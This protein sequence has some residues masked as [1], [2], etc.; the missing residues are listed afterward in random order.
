MFLTSKLPTYQQALEVAKSSNGV[1]YETKS[2]I[3]GYDI[4]VF[5]YRLSTYSDFVNYRGFELRG[6]TFVFN[7]DG[8][9]FATYPLLTKFFNLNENP[10]T[11]IKVLEDKRISKVFLKEDGS[12]I[13][14]IKLP[15]GKILPKSKVGLSSFQ[16]ELSKQLFEVDENLKHFVTSCLDLGLHPIFELVSNKN[17]IVINYNTTKLILLS[18]RNNSGEYLDINDFDWEKPMSFNFSLSDLISLKSH[19]T[20]IEG[21]VV[22]FDD[23]QRVKIKTDWYLSLHRVLT[24]YS[25]REDYLIDMILSEKIDDLLGILDFESENRKFV[26]SVIEKTNSKINYYIKEVNRLISLY[27]DNKIEE[28][29]TTHQKNELFSIVMRVLR[30]CDIMDSLKT[31]IRKK[32]YRLNQ[33]RSWL[34]SSS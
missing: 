7:Y 9:T 11:D 22:I 5:N 34:S 24:D 12:V 20:G 26:E 10:S 28:F 27:D 8:S 18:V 21:W 23:G 19:L 3:D 6:L 25:N 33:A 16:S 32:T 29:A 4:S 2:K 15:N 17:Q 13:S 30:G 31:L 14:F 1:F